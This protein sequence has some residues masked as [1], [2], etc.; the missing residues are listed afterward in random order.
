MINRIKEKKK[1]KKL[2]DGLADAIFEGMSP[3]IS[4]LSEDKTKREEKKLYNYFK[5]T[6][7]N[8]HERVKDVSIVND[9]L[10]TKIIVE[11]QDQENNFTTKKYD[12]EKVMNEIDEVEMANI[13]LYIKVRE[14]Y[15]VFLGLLKEETV[16][17]VN[18]L[19]AADYIHAM[20][21]M[22]GLKEF[23]ENHNKLTIIGTKLKDYAFA[24]EDEIKELDEALTLLAKRCGIELEKNV[25][26]TESSIREIVSKENLSTQDVNFMTA[27]IAY[28]KDIEEENKDLFKYST[29]SKLPD[30]KKIELAYYKV[31]LEELTDYEFRFC[32]EH[33]KDGEMLTKYF[34]EN[35]QKVK[36]KL[37]EIMNKVLE[38]TDLEDREYVDLAFMDMEY[39]NMALYILLKP[40]TLED[41]NKRI[42]VLESVIT[43]DSK[44]EHLY[45]RK[46]DALECWKRLI[47]ILNAKDSRYYDQLYGLTYDI[48][49]K[50][51]ADVETYIKTLNTNEE[52][53]S[54][55]LVSDY[56]HYVILKK[57]VE[58]SK[59]GEIE[60][61]NDIKEYVE[62]CLKT[63]DKDDYLINISKTLRRVGEDY[64]KDI[65]GYREVLQACYNSYNELAIPNDSTESTCKLREIVDSQVE[66]IEKGMPTEI[67]SKIREDKL[68]L[69]NK[70]RK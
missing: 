16:K 15:E 4:A 27:A 41:I 44:R 51:L 5:N 21:L 69:P 2:A 55:K 23:E 33:V 40:Y 65:Y 8:D 70:Y 3:F 43:K 39:S 53:D 52:Y 61:D 58:L 1:S 47:S 42:K 46:I 36:R 32:R 20:A 10:G 38:G 29:F 28:L 31:L 11:L 63:I 12:Y 68:T 35:S 64:P 37:N 22:L 25:S 34:S 67:V 54:D 9:I 45:K 57:I 60:I 62:D 17:I 50:H 7:D 66:T 14:R 59:S 18:N 13:K 26:L 48:L 49:E 19:D 56:Q 6:L 30:S 24:L